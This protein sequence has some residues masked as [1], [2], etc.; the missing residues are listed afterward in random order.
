MIEADR[1][2]DAGPAEVDAE[3]L[4][5]AVT[6]AAAILDLLAGDSAVAYGPSEIARRLGLPKSSVANVCGTLADVGL[7]R[8]VG[9]G[10]RPRPEAGRA[11]WG[12]PRRDGR[13]PGVLRSVP[14]PPDG[15]RGNRPA[16]RPRWGRDD[17]P[18]P[19]RWPTAGP[20]DLADR[21]TPPGDLDGD[22]Q[23]RAC[24]AG[25]AGTGAAPRRPDAA[26]GFHPEHAPDRL[27]PD[28]RSRRGARA[29][30]CPG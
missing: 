26:A 24:V 5:P 29:R 6:R 27:E 13:R 3:S 8:R 19:A 10:F 21:T 15:L 22:R 7:L 30:V 17:I 2:T 18:R 23:G 11:R 9:T 4:A 16:G 20:P 1:A 28:G 25:R 12:I 14:G